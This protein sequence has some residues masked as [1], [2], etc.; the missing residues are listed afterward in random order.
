[1]EI[2]VD[3]EIIAGLLGHEAENARDY[4]FVGESSARRV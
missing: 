3:G 1:M 2:L 4:T